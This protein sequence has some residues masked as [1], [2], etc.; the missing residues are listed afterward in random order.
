MGARQKLNSIAAGGIF[1]VAALTGLGFQSWLMF[2]VVGGL[3][4]MA[5]VGNGDIRT[6]PRR[7]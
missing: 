6:S 5:A 3:L 2:F 4:T 1:V 7:R